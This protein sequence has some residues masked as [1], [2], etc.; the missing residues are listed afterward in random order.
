M[1]TTMTRLMFVKKGIFHLLAFFKLI[2]AVSC[3]ATRASSAVSLA[4][5]KPSLAKVS[6]TDW[7]YQALLLNAR[8][9]LVATESC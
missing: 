4:A 7:L 9:R 2:R 8:K 1:P 6:S 3:K 5:D